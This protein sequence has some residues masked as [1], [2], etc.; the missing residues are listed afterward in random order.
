ME[1]T[2]IQCK[3]QPVTSEFCDSSQPRTAGGQDTFGFPSGVK[4]V[5][6]HGRVWKFFTNGVRNMAQEIRQVGTRAVI[7]FGSASYATWV[8]AISKRK[9]SMKLKNSKWYN[10]W[11][12]K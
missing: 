12:G 3:F 1:T 11:D 7:R 4:H 9:A 5:K 10:S 2:L 8:Q 6:P